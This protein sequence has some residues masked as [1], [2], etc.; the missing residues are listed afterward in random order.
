MPGID[1]NFT[2]PPSTGDANNGPWLPLAGT[3][4]LPMQ[5][6]LTSGKNPQSLGIPTSAL[7]GAGSFTTLTGTTGGSTSFAINAATARNFSLTWAATA[8]TCD[9]AVPTNLT[10]GIQYTIK[11]SQSNPA[12]TGV[13]GVSTALTWLFGRGAKVLS[14]AAAAIDVL[15]FKYDGSKIL[16]ELSTAY[17]T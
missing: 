4:T 3:E 9:L 5:T 2:T 17:S 13:M 12:T 10:P 1:T 16:A 15:N 14:T 7:I 6:N 11:I 8:P